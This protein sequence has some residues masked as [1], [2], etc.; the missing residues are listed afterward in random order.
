MNV[1]IQL[2]LVMYNYRTGF[3]AAITSYVF[4]LNIV[5]KL[6]YCLDIFDGMQAVLCELFPVFMQ[7]NWVVCNYQ[8]SS[9]ECVVIIFIIIFIS[10]VDF[11]SCKTGVWLVSG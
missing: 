6:H 10:P 9:I 2:D 3:F 4:C 7:P 11:H 1:F 5:T 8:L